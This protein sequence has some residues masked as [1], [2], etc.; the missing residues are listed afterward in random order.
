MRVL[1][2]RFAARPHDSKWL[3]QEEQPML[4]SLPLSSL[5]LMVFIYM[6]GI[7]HNSLGKTVL[8]H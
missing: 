4:F 7:A 2:L 6:I 1:I 8:M 3:T 5:I